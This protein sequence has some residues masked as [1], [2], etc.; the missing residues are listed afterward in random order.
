MAE[1]PRFDVEGGSGANFRNVSAVRPVGLQAEAQLFDFVSRDFEIHSEQFAQAQAAAEKAQLAERDIALDLKTQEIRERNRL[2]PNGFARDMDNYIL[3]TADNVPDEIRDAYI[4]R[5]RQKTASAFIQE[6]QNFVTHQL[7]VG[8]REAKAFLEIQE[9]RLLSYGAPEN[10]IDLQLINDDRVIYERFLESELNAGNMTPSEVN[11][12]KQSLND[13]MQSSYLLGKMQQ[14]DMPLDFLVDVIGG[15]TDDPILQNLSPAAKQEALS[16]GQQLF[17][18]LQQIEQRDE[19]LRQEL[20]D[21][22][23]TIHVDTIYQN[24]TSPTAQD[25]IKILRSLAATPEERKKVQDLQE[26]V[27]N[28]E[29]KRYKESDP[30]TVFDVESELARGEL[31]QTRLDDLHGNGLSNEDFNKYRNRLESERDSLVSSPTYQLIKERMDEEFP[32]PKKLSQTE[33]LLSMFGGNDIPGISKD[34]NEIARLQRNEKLKT[35][36]LLDIKTQ[37]LE[38]GN[39]NSETQLLEAGNA[40]LV[41][42]RQEV[43]QGSGGNTKPSP[44]GNP[45]PKSAAL[46]DTNAIAQHKKYIGKPDMLRQDIQNGKLDPATGRAIFNLIKEEENARAE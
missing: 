7:E 28:A 40:A 44:T 16:Q 30:S 42:M 13:K 37:I 14:N 32:G 23:K 21:A 36:M 9:N 6:R 38:Q 41:K 34:P 33:L 22:Q 24:P 35:Q 15:E 17:S 12:R 4:L 20:V 25:S 31:S 8:K 3:S 19:R 10:E 5:A 2:N 39:I 26:F 18:A 45:L 43:L 27:A 1:I 11:L 29:S 46:Q